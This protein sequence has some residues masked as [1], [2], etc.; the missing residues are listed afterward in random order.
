[1]AESDKETARLLRV[2]SG[3][4][5]APRKIRWFYERAWFQAVAISILLT[6]MGGLI[7]W[8]SRPADP[9]QLFLNAQILMQSGDWDKQMRARNGPIQNFLRHYADRQLKWSHGRIR[10]ISPCGKDSCERA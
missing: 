2:A 6:A 3:K 10:R 5:A 1:L 9:H 4:K 7:Y 8:A